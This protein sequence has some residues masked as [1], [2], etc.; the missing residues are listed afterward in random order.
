MPTDDRSDARTT[1]ARPDL[2]LDSLEGI[3][4]A[5]R[6]AP[7]RAKQCA[8]PSLALRRTTSDDSEQMS[9]LLFGE[10]FDV[11]EEAGGWAF[12]QA[13]RDRYV[14]YVRAEALIEPGPAPTHWVSALR[15]FAFVEANLKSRV[16]DLISLNA[17]VA[18]ETE[19]YRFAKIA[20]S[21]W[22][23]K[24]HLTPIGETAGEDW[25][26]T[27]EKFVGA[28]YLWGGRESLGV[29]CSAL[30]QNARFA[31]GFTCPRDSDMQAAE[32]GEPIDGSSLQRGDLVFWKGHVAIMTDAVR[33]V[34]AN[35]FH[36]ATAIEPLAGAIARIA[37]TSTGAPTGYR[38][39]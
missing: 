3:I 35:G 39:L 31:S 6:Y 5:E 15:T 17:L 19:D 27:A 26:A 2:A 33:M 34:H 22:V 37:A 12:G 10:D 16:V 29:D 9:Q 38:R 23:F 8:R 4:A 13:R 28:P 24:P 36:M 7:A 14:G 20:G 25:V 21:G 11:L 1:L 30:V 32:L 18:V